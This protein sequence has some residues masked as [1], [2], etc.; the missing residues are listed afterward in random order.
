MVSLK[1][2]NNFWRT[3]QISLTNFEI[4]LVLSWSS[5]CV[6]S[7]DTKAT[8]FVKTDRKLYI[9]VVTLSFQY[10]SKLLQQFISDCML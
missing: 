6:L 1:H 7:K 9:P 5:E 3:L 2:F 8:T 4:N 10:H